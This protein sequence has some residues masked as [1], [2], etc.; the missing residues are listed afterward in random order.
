LGQYPVWQHLL[1]TVPGFWFRHSGIMTQ[2][3][4]RRA[5]GIDVGSEQLFC[6]V[7][8]GPVRIFSTFTSALIELKD[9]L[10]EQQVTTVAMEATGVYWIPVF[11][12]LDE[13]GLE[14]WVV[15]AAHA[16]N[17][18]A[19]K[20]DMKDCQWL[21][22]LHSK[23]MLNSGFIPPASIRELRDYTRLRADHVQMASPHVLHMHKALDQMN[24][25]IHEVLSDVTGA[26]GQ[27]L[28]QAII[29]GER[30]AQS[31]LALCDAQVL[32]NKRQRMLDALQGRWK[33]SQLFALRQAYEN[34]THYQKQIA[35]C[36]QQ[37]AQVLQRLAAQQL[38][39]PPAEPGKTKRLHKNGPDIE[40]LGS[41]LRRITGG[42]DL[43]QLPCLTDYSIMQL[44]AEVGTSMTRWAT[45]KHFTAWLGLAPGARQSGKTKKSQRRFRGPAGRLF[46]LIAQSL[47]RSKYLALGGFYRR[48]RGR[49][50]G[51]V[52]NIAAAR[53]LAVLFYNTLRYG[54]KYVEQGLAEYEKNY[55][56]QSLKR[57]KAT[58]KRFGMQLIPEPLTT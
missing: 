15:N 45:A 54:W 11:E 57:L 49:R 30:Q 53:K 42:Q 16:R 10:L 32:K 44:I 33:D 8:A 6:A 12:V 40:E 37:I 4:Q 5:A 41:L 13:A 26:S 2:L 9:H 31:L 52:A 14:V 25:K 38:P 29:A 21:A 51:Q 19:R 46:C 22:Q 20:T 7:A 27:R 34:W 3:K 50:G 28:L 43:T 35:A 56:Q 24:I 48:I 1:F 58:A 17:V 36:D 55:K 47:A 39:P 23:Q 18:P